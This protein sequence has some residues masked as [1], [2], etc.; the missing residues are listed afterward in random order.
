MRQV[1]RREEEIE[2]GYTGGKYC[3]KHTVELWKK[4]NTNGQEKRT[5]QM[6]IDEAAGDENVGQNWRLNYSEAVSSV[7]DAA[8]KEVLQVDSNTAPNNFYEHV[9]PEEVFLVVREL[10]KSTSPRKKRVCQRSYIKKC[11]CFAL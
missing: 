5:V 2:A 8:E 1:K 9:S 10:N 7:D 6:R 11:I 4:L 3:E